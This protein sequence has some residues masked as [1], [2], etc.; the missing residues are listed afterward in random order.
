[1]AETAG[2]SQEAARYWDW[3]TDWSFQYISLFS[4]LSPTSALC[5]V[6]VICFSVCASAITIL[7]VEIRWSTVWSFSWISNLDLLLLTSGKM[8]LSLHL[9]RASMYLLSTSHCAGHR[10]TILDAVLISL[11][12]HSLRV[13]N[14]ASSSQKSIKWL[15]QWVSS[16]GTFQQTPEA[17]HWAPTA[18]LNQALK[19][20]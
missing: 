10:L 7:R 15:K 8:R 3:L 4:R 14:S 11:K 9:K 12:I 19:S 2:C 20:H 6:W 13:T 1:V 5:N 16:W 18:L 17:I